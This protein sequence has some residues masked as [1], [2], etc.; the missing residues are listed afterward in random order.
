M[1]SEK[2]P[3]SMTSLPRKK[4]EKMFG[5]WYG[6]LL[7]S[8]HKVESAAITKGLKLYK[9]SSQFFVGPLHKGPQT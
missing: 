4:G 9:H 2:Q 5:L 8:K 6:K 7:I 3:P 1:N